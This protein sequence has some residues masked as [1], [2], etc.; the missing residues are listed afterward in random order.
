VEQV[1]AGF[2]LVHCLK[3]HGSTCK[4]MS[5]RCACPGRA[6][7]EETHQLA[8]LRPRDR[9]RRPRPSWC[10]G[11]AAGAARTPPGAQGARALPRGKP[12]RGA[13]APR[14]AGCR[15]PA[16]LEMANEAAK[17]QTRGSNTLRL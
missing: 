11:S 7:A 14:A 15:E 4:S 16:S 10:L 12:R 13:P 17:A 9:C 8:S 2:R 3:I 6:Q 5:A 1:D